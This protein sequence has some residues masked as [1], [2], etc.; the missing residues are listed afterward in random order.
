[1][2]KYGFSGSQAKRPRESQHPNEG[3]LNLSHYKISFR[4]LR[5]V[6]G[7]ATYYLQ[8][9]LDCMLFYLAIWLGSGK[10]YRCEALWGEIFLFF[11]NFGCF[12]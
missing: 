1:M 5:L 4:I 10:D 2:I 7:S 12:L 11:L 9:N 8:S 6:T 3:E